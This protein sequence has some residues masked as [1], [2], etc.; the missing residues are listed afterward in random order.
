MRVGTLPLERGKVLARPVKSVLVTNIS[1][2]GYRYQSGDKQS[3][4]VSQKEFASN[5]KS[6][7]ATR[8]RRASHLGPTSTALYWFKAFAVR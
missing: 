4:D 7:I 5:A 8:D 6:D 2:N 1:G 3:A